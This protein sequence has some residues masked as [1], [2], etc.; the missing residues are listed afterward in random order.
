M[1]ALWINA[2]DKAHVQVQLQCCRTEDEP[3]LLNLFQRT[4]LELREVNKD[5]KTLNE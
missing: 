1:S 2:C 3:G 4:V 5:R